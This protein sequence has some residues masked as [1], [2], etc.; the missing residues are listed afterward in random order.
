MHSERKRPHNIWWWLFRHLSLTCVHCLRIDFKKPNYSIIQ[1]Y[2]LW[3]Y[4]KDAVSLK[5]CVFAKNIIKSSNGCYTWVWESL[6]V[7]WYF[8]IRI[9]VNISLS[10]CYVKDSYNWKDYLIEY[11]EGTMKPPI[12]KVLLNAPNKQTEKWE[13]I[14][15][16]MFQL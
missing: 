2:T 3:R 13:N 1:S 10:G 16:E 12:H 9:F 7:F 14:V 4:L 11:A 15:F 8:I 6:Q 5:S